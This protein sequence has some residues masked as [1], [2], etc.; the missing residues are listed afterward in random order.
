MSSFCG[1]LQSGASFVLE[2]RMGWRSQNP[3]F[4]EWAGARCLLGTV[5]YAF[6]GLPHVWI[7]RLGTGSCFEKGKAARQKAARPPKAWMRGLKLQC[8]LGGSSPIKF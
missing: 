2:D 8:K 7:G 5:R 4:G 3:W 6:N 1:D